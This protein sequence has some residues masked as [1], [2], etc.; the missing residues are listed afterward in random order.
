MHVRHFYYWNECIS[1]LKDTYACEV[2]GIA[3][4][5][6]HIEDSLPPSVSIATTIF[7][8]PNVCF[9]VS[10]RFGFP[11]GAIEHCDKFVHVDI[12]NSDYEHLVHFDAKTSICLQ[13]Y[14]SQSGKSETVFSGGKYAVEAPMKEVVKPRPSR[15]LAANKI[16]T[17]IEV[18]LTDLFY[19][20]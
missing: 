18:D 3:L 12:P 11:S 2:I 6:R 10:N 8:T 14:T 20:C 4:S 5:S 17:S 19:Q 13:H 9:I 7:A 16:D 15:V 1:Y